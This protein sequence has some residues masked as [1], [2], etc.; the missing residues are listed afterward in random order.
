M[1]YLLLVYTENEVRGRD[2]ATA[3]VPQK[4]DH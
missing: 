3:R 2:Q 4:F 1:F